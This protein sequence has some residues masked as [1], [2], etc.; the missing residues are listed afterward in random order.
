[1][2]AIL[3]AA[4]A[5]L[6][7]LVLRPLTGVGM[8]SFRFALSLVALVGSLLASGCSDDL[9][10]GAVHGKITLH[11]SPVPFAY[12]QFTPVDPPGTY[13]AAYSDINGEYVLQFSKSREGA[14]IGKHEVLVRTSTR[15]EIQVEDKTTGLMVTP[16]L[17]KGYQEK[18]ETKFQRE[19]QEGD[20]EIHFELN[21][22]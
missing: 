15:D 8:R 6:T 20:N 17:P 18:L 10:L 3:T 1:M 12:V 2:F 13:G 16:Q 4:I 21:Q 5:E 11:G 22:K 14:P 9:N 19:V 7:S